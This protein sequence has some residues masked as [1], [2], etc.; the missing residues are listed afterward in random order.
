MEGNQKKKTRAEDHENQ[1]ASQRHVATR[2]SRGHGQ[3]VRGRRRVK[4]GI[5]RHS[6]R[7]ANALIAHSQRM[8]I[9]QKEQEKAAQTSSKARNAR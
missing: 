7:S 9:E 5:D 2:S 8:V 3:R 1:R 4:E 6:R